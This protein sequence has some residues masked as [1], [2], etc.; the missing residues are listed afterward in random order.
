VTF[1]LGAVIGLAHPREADAQQGPPIPFI[2]VSSQYQDLDGD[3]DMFPDTGETG[4]VVVVV[5]NK[6]G[7]LTNAR[8]TISSSDPDV[9]CITSGTVNVGAVGNGQTVTV[10]S[11]NPNLPGLE[12]RASRMLQTLVATNPARI[13]LCLT[14]TANEIPNGVG[15]VC[16]SLIADLDVPAGAT[17]TFVA[18][19]D[20]IPGTADD[21]TV[22]ENFDVDRDGDG[23]ITVNDTFRLADAGTGTIGHGSFLRGAAASGNTTVGG[24]A[25]GGFQTVA[26]GNPSCTLDPDFPLDWHIHCPPG[27]TNCPN[28]ESGA[29]VGGCSFDTPADGAKAL[30]PPNSMHMGA[31]FDSSSSL[32]GDTTHLRSLQAFV[33]GPLNLAVIPRPG[34]LQLSMFHIVDFMD[35]NGVGPGNANQCSDCGD[36]QI[37]VDR[38][39]NPAV[40]DWGFW[41]KLVPFQNVYDHKPLAFSTFGGYYC[42]FTPTDTATTVGLPSVRETMCFPLGAWSHCGSV[43]GTTSTT[44]ADCAGPG[45]LDPTGT[46]V[47]VET[48][49][50]LANFLGQRVRLRW[51]GSTWDFDGTSSS[52]FEVGP[53]WSSTL[54]DDGWWLDNISVTGVITSQT[55]PA[56]DNDRPPRGGGH[57]CQ[58]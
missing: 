31:H 27:A 14:L 51:I 54:Q 24:V 20:G 10:G 43:R 50:N 34:D 5:Q 3:L 25:C 17:Q 53:G 2:L 40:D 8:F 33:S 7:A 9:D 21:G 12:F 16:F 19:P 32:D 38:N 36:V 18:G 35:N 26:Q 1:L 13:D 6:S 4:R 56:P 55:T 48:R 46:G 49:F 22:L 39:P 41:D 11:L 44:V 37:Q 58:H 15:P 45:V 42:L 30:S 52:Y 47:W 29:C 23:F 57:Q 28:L